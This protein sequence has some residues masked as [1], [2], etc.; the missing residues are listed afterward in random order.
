MDID[1]AAFA[2]GCLHNVHPGQVV[3]L[4]GL[5]GERIRPRNGRLRRD[6]RRRCRKDD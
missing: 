3:E 1:L 5:L 4:N 2:G 6:D